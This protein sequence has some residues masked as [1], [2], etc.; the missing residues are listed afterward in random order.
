MAA[1]RIRVMISSRCDDKL[2]RPDG[3]TTRMSELRIEAKARIESFELFGQPSF[4]CWVHED[5]P[6]MDATADFWDQCL[7]R[8]RWSD[9][10]LALYNGNAGFGKQ[11]SDIGICHAELAAALN[12][13]PGRVRIIDVQ[14][15]NAAPPKESTKRNQR[16]R[17]YLD[18]QAIGM[19]FAADTDEALQLLL[20]ALQD[21]VVELVR[22][23]SAS[24]RKGRFDTGAPLDWSRLDFAARKAA[25]ER[26]VAARLEEDSATS[27]GPG[28]VRV[29]DDVPVL[30]CCHAIP[31][32]MG[33]ASARE[34]AGR[35]FLRD[36]EL[37]PHMSDKTAGP[38]HIIACHRSV[39]E[40]QASAI[41]G[42][43]DATVVTPQFGVYVADDIQKI[44]L[45]FLANCRDESSTRYA[46]QRLFDWLLGTGEAS[47]L[48]ERARG[49]KAIVSEIAVQ[50]RSQ[51]G[52]TKR[53]G[54]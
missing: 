3:R 41:L 1:K 49:R 11:H 10:V 22:Q 14:Q 35:P 40:G 20:E 32:G 7:K 28:Y 21:A 15:A 29:V 37:T 27:A 43:P 8:V 31:A 46:I 34:M 50:Q 25:M 17:E 44:Q 54:G 18:R 51:R 13:A 9:V 2:R 42:F 12:T 30:F 33:I 38:V 39:S 26:V 53:A 5:E 19:R 6:A 47:F 4:E 16:F 52:A 24:A 48:A 23:G 36:H 45:V